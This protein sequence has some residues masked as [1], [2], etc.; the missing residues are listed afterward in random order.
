MT[1]SQQPQTGVTE[2]SSSSSGRVERPSY[3][4]IHARD[5]TTRVLYV[6]SGVEDALGYSAE[7]LINTR[8]VDLMEESFDAK[9]L[10]QMFAAGA[11]QTET[12]S[13]Y[14]MYVNIKTA[15]GE[16]ILHRITWFQ[17][18]DCVV[19]IGISF[20]EVE[21]T[22]RTNL[23]ARQ[24][25][26]GM[27]ALDISQELHEH[28]RLTQHVPQT[29][30]TQYTQQPHA[31]R[32]QN[33][34]Y[35]SHSDRIK[36]AFVLEYLGAVEGE[37]DQHAGQLAGPQVVFVTGSVSRLIDA[38]TSD[39]THAPFLKFVAPEDVLQV[40]KFLDRLFGTTDVMFETFSLL[41][42]PPIVEGDVDVAD[43]D[44]PRVVVEC[45]GAASRDGVM[46]LVRRLHIA[47]APKRDT[48]GNYIRTMVHKVDDE[49]SGYISLAELISSD[50]DTS[51]APDAWSQL[52]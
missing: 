38:D 43:D 44:N 13:A 4:G 7:S 5:E 11:G 40:G 9:D 24:L 39:L 17:C 26:G 28:Q 25:D 1:N 46:L 15:F 49:D 19:Y 50:P 31:H 22:K 42:R 10:L 33:S 52:L 29:P 20:P 30:Q 18:S 32:P 3:I 41:R 37:T 36:A 47:C 45:L 8:A 16:P 23:A 12:S 14:V 34:V 21:Y 27:K 51:D 35:Y 48:A 6:S 2:N